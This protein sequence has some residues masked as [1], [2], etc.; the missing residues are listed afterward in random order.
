[1][2]EK[3]VKCIITAMSVEFLAITE[4]FHIERSLH[5]KLDDKYVIAEDKE[6]GIV[7][8]QSGV[9]KTA[10]EACAKA[11]YTQF[12]QVSGFISTGLAGAL[13][14][15]L[16]TGDILI[17]DTIIENTQSEWKRIQIADHIVQ[18]MTNHNVNCGSIY[19][20]DKFINNADE[21]QRLNAETGAICVEME[22]GGIASFAKEN[23]IPF[24]A[25]KVISDH[26]DEKALRSMIRIYNMACDKLASYLNDIINVAFIA[27]E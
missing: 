23:G 19:S 12:P 21:K 24:A 8:A 2:I 6:R 17:G 3:K 7:I 15:Q 26:A 10:A 13:S 20:S 11:I 16:N 14:A 1:M 9:R 18:S 22:S 25:I 27:S 5:Y 4:C